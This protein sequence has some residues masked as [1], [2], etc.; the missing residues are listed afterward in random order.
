MLGHKA[1]ESGREA[2]ESERKAHELG[3]KAPAL[4]LGYTVREA[5]VGPTQAQGDVHMGR[6]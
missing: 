6:E 3:D 5:H 2:R 4:A 1:R